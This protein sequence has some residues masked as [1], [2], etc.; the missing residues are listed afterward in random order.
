MQNQLQRAIN[1][2]KKTGD[3]LIIF[4]SAKT[5]EACIVLPLE[6]YEN[7][8]L[9][10]S[11]KNLTE[12]ELLDKVNCDI[13]IWKN[14][15]ENE[16]EI[17]EKNDDLNWSSDDQLNKKTE[18]SWSIP[19]TRKKNAEDIIEEDRQYLEEVTF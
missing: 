11:K 19:S 2:S 8:V 1:L 15:S 6:D 3:K 12:N 9:N 18:K 5:E 4:D 16:S 17:E 10:R 7:L 13:A 14:E